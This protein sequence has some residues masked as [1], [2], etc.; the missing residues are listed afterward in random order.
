MEFTAQKAELGETVTKEET[1]GTSG[2]QTSR[3]F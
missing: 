1:E 3:L 2:G